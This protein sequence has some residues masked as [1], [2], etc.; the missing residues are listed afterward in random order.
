[1]RVSGL[2]LWAAIL[3]VAAGAML[4]ATRY[5]VGGWSADADISLSNLSSNDGA[6]LYRP[7]TSRMRFAIAAVL[8][9][10]ATLEN[11]QALASYLSTRLGRPIEIVQSKSYA[12]TNA[13]LRSG[14][15]SLALV[16]SGAFVIGRRDFGM[17]PLV[18]P[19]VK[20]QTTYNSY[21]VV[22][23]T[24][25]VRTW[26]DL[27]HKTFAFTDPLSNSGRLVPVFVLSEMGETPERFFRDFI[28]TYSH[29]KS[30]QAVADGLVDGAAIDSLVYDS[31]VRQ[32]PS[33]ASRVK[34]VWKSP[35]YGINPVVVHPNI[36]PDLRSSL[37]AI[38]LGMSADTEGRGVLARLGIDS[39]TA[40]D[41]RAYDSIETML[42][43]TA[44]R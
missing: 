4:L 8:S 2:A 13:L 29:D 42:R 44:A 28:F 14:D 6:P 30:V 34:V 35:A 23:S 39:F 40:P 10:R 24:S 1:M 3:A 16:C 21:L 18:V 43:A 25:P 12:E 17:Q 33:M 32:D 27:R 36:S 5:D 11:Y 20:G 38:F 37:E 22:P 7:D 41:A 26:E 19:V 15:V 9:P 31:M